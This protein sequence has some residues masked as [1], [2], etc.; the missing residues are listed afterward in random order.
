MDD[1]SVWLCVTTCL[2][3]TLEA[4]P[5]GWQLFLLGSSQ[6]DSTAFPLCFDTYATR[7]L[8]QAL[9]QNCRTNSTIGAILPSSPAYLATPSCPR[10]APSPPRRVPL[11]AASNSH[12]GSPLASL[13]TA[14]SC[15]RSLRASPV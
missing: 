8:A 5:I 13:E 9:T 4:A 6:G 2:T 10:A 3:P 1:A 12:G 11:G 15:S 14:P 7:L